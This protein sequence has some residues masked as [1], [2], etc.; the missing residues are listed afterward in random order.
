[1]RQFFRP[2]NGIQ[3]L[4]LALLI[5]MAAGFIYGFRIVENVQRHQNDGLRTV[6]CLA[7]GFVKGSHHIDAQ[8][9][10]QSLRFYNQAL[11]KAHLRSCDA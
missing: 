6:I 7:E 2:L 9:R 4:T 3:Y 1:M 10:A 5:V 11:S 8:Q